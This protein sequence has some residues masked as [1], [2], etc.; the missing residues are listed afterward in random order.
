MFSATLSTDKVRENPQCFY[1]I[2]L[3]VFLCL[4]SALLWLT[5]KEAKRIEKKIK[6]NK[7]DFNDFLGQLNQIKKMGDLKSL[8]GMIPGMSKITKNLDVDDKAFGKVEAI[9]KS[10]TPD[11]RAQP[12]LLNMSRKR[13]IAKG[14]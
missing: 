13:R 8:M 5:Q 10:M 7:F 4:K 1:N 6:K 14:K 12:K 11:E 2:S 9:I 3:R